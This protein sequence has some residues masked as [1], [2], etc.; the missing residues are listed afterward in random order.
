MGSKLEC[1]F[2]EAWNQYRAR[3]TDPECTRELNR[4]V[5]RVLKRFDLVLILVSLQTGERKVMKIFGRTDGGGP[6]EATNNVGAIL[7]NRGLL[8]IIQDEELESIDLVK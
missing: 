5:P 3:P 1:R 6:R 2:K 7:A 8:E 4:V